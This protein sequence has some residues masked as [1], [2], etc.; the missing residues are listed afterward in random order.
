[1]GKNPLIRKKETSYTSPVPNQSAGILDDFAVRRNIA[2]NAGTVEKTPVEHN[3][4]VNKEYVDD[5]ATVSAIQLFMTK[6]SSDVTDYF[7]LDSSPDTAAEQTITTSIAGN[8]TATV[9][10]HVSI[11][12]DEVVSA[13]EL[14]ESGVYFC[15]MHPSSTANKKTFLSCTFHKRDSGDV[16]TQIGTTEEVEMSTSEGEFNM[17]ILIANDTAW[18]AT[19][20]FVMKTICRNA[21]ASSKDVTIRMKSDKFSRV[22]FP[23]FIA[24]TFVADHASAHEVGGGDLVDHDNLTNFLQTEHFTE[25]S[26]DHTN[27]SNIGTNTHAQIDTHVALVNEHIDWTSTS[28]NLSTTGTI[29]ASGTINTVAQ[30]E[31]DNINVLNASGGTLLIGQG[32]STNITEI[33]ASAGELVMTLDASKNV[34]MVG[35]LAVTGTGTFSEA[36]TIST[37]TTGTQTLLSLKS[38]AGTEIYAFRKDAGDDGLLG[39][40][41]GDGTRKIQLFA[42]GDTFFNGGNVGI[43]IEAPLSEL[44]ILSVNDPVIFIERSD[45]VVIDNNVIS[46]IYSRGGEADSAVTVA[47]MEIEADAAWTDTSSPTKFL[48]SLTPTGST[49]PAEVFRIDSNGRLGAGTIAPLGKIH[50][51]QAST[52]GAIPVLYLDQADISEEFIRFI[53]A[54]AA[55]ATRTVSTLNTSGATT[56]H[57][58]INLNGTKAWI[59]VSTN[60]PT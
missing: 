11:L 27:I 49:T 46:G 14:I 4:I 25:A 8:T 15:H 2:S 28:S 53:G 60:D 34:T 36:V 26:I 50:G 31:I 23:A 29:N 22:E 7:D 19:D 38:D 9:A 37:T 41:I 48:L 13:I 42:D 20:R 5:Q 3:D 59:A 47:K 21:N 58:Q 44:H 52:T 18:T 10:S 56:D 35:D 54:S 43:G 51:D 45:A 32:S 39:I 57:I 6:D 55:D 40:N 24:P 30:F 12:N 33:Y 16:E 1:M 17:H